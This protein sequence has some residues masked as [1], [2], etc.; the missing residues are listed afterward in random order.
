MVDMKQMITL[1]KQVELRMDKMY[2]LF[3]LENNDATTIYMMV[4][5]VAINNILAAGASKEVIQEYVDG[6]IEEFNR[7]GGRIQ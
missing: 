4:L 6:H 3:K 5:A 2:N 1:T 7:P